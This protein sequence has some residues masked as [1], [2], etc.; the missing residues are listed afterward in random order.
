MT[1]ATIKRNIFYSSSA[2]CT[3]IDELPAGK[4]RTTEDRRGRK[5][6]ESKD[7]DTDYNVYYCAADNSLGETML[8]KQQIDGVDAHSL[9]VDPLFVAPANGDF[10]FK[11]E[12]PALE[13]GI[14][15]FDTSQV[16][17]RK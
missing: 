14:V 2:T 11:P 9:A 12:S 7:A 6:A 17:L 10:R 15:P 5:L 3:F 8:K 1:G 13:M 4:G 16:G